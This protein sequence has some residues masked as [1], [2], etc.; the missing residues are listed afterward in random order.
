MQLN[1]VTIGNSK[2]IVLFQTPRQ[3]WEKLFKAELQAEEEGNRDILVL[4]NVWDEE[5]WE[6]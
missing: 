3:G 4:Q 6:W 2:G 1:L 5:E